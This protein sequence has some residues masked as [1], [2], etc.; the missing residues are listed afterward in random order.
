MKSITRRQFA[1]LLTAG[2]AT[3]KVF[4][5]SASVHIQNHRLVNMQGGGIK[6]EKWERQHLHQCEECQELLYVFVTQP[7]V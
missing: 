7:N 2:L 1:A 6:L 5:S 4:A 3:E